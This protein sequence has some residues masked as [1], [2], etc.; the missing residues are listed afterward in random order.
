MYKKNNNLVFFVYTKKI[1]ERLIEISEKDYF[2][3]DFFRQAAHW[4]ELF[5]KLLIDLMYGL[6][7]Q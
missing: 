1:F 2:F 5:E 7:D 4:G 3:K 6:Y